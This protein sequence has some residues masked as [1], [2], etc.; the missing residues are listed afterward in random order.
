MAPSPTRTL[1][2]LPPLQFD[3]VAAGRG[4]SCASTTERP[5][6]VYCWGQSLPFPRGAVLF[7]VNG[8]P[9]R[10]DDLVAGDDFI[11]VRGPADPMSAQDP[12]ADSVWCGGS[13]G[14]GGPAMVRVDLAPSCPDVIPMAGNCPTRGIVAGGGHVCV[15]Y[16]N[17]AVACWGRGDS[18]ELGDGSTGTSL[19]PGPAL[20]EPVLTSVVAAGAHHTCAVGASE[21]WCWGADDHGQL[22]DGSTA[23]SA[24]PIP[25]LMT[26]P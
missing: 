9:W 18:G 14:N 17:G 12:N 26:C 13:L 25:V 7:D 22:G 23:A 2:E 21:L 1:L 4:F 19:K 8:V 15:L 11:C 3:R 6:R 5:T 24:T 20:A 10:V 16:G